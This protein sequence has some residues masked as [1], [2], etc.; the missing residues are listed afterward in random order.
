[1]LCH[2]V[3]TNKQKE[4]C[5]MQTTKLSFLGAAALVGVSSM[6]FAQAETPTISEGTQIFSAFAG[7]QWFDVADQIDGIGDIGDD[8]ETELNLG[9]RYQYNLSPHVGLEGN[10]MF[11]PAQH[12]F[13]G[14]E[15]AGIGPSDMDAFYYMGNVVYNISPGSRVVPFLTGGVGAV[16]LRVD[17]ADNPDL[18]GTTTKI[19]GNIGAGLLWAVGSRFG[20]RFEVRDYV[21]RLDEQ[22]V[23][24]RHAFNIPAGFAETVNDL[25]FTG[26]FSV[27]F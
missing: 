20:L 18:S 9:L 12:E 14:P 15:D 1:L 26:G 23:Q 17:P 24:F 16:T 8:V 11:S 3:S 4:A 2:D 10:F 13:L 5:T 25:A 19:A 7:A 6:V 27:L 22:D 21:Y